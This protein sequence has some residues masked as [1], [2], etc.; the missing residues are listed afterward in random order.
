[1]NLAALWRLP[2]VFV[3]ENNRWASSTAHRLSTAGGSI[4]ARAAGYGI[5]GATVDGNDALAVYDAVWRAAEAARR[6]EGPS[7]IE[8]H[9]IRWVG[10]F[11]GDGQAYR[12]KEEVEEGRRRDPIARLGR[13]LADRG[14]LDL[15]GAER[16]RAAVREEI[17]DAVMFAEASPF[18]EP[19]DALTD[20]FAH[21]PWSD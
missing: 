10:H 20:L 8:A 7:L 4:A 16:M 19:A 5:P 13:W 11:E 6:G 15:P 2:V 9:T 12:G 17:E 14:L 1:V 18:P 21:Y 3:C